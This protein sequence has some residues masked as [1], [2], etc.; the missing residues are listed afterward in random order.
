M[1]EYEQTKTISAPAGETFAWLS[2][3]GNLPHYLPPVKE[4]DVEGQPAEGR[5]GKRIRIRV[6]VP[7]RYETEAEGYFHVDE[8]ARRMEWGAEM[9]R[10]YSGWL[11]VEEAGADESTVRVHLSFGPRSVEEQAQEE[12]SEER[13]PMQEGVEATLESIRRQVEESSGK[14]KPTSPEG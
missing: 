12:S 3:A 14:L 7:G 8:G 13:D 2:D 10:D 11:S 1:Q 4:V 6:E 9:G 5:P